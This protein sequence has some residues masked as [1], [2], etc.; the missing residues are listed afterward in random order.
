MVAVV[1]TFP[2]MTTMFLDRGHAP[3]PTGGEVN[4]MMDSAKPA[5]SASSGN[6]MG[7]SL[8]GNSPKPTTPEPPKPSNE[9][10]FQLDGAKPA[11]STPSSEP[12]KP[13]NEFNFQIEKPAGQ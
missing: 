3:L 1:M 7:F 12:A 4:F 13:S 8:D 6:E 10:N 11:Q 9:M 2:K 5:P